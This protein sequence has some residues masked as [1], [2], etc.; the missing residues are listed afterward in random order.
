MK[1]R[2]LLHFTTVLL[3][4][5]IVVLVESSFSSVCL[6]FTVFSAGLHQGL[7]G[8]STQESSSSQRAPS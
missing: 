8:K 6:L 5:I 3:T 7:R 2:G 4:V 1:H